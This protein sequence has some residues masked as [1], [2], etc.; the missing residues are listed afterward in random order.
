MVMDQAPLTLQT[1]FDP[2][3]F[4][5]SFQMG[6]KL[7]GLD[8]TKLN[9]FSK[10]YGD[11]DFKKGWFDLVVEVD[12]KEGGFDGYVKP[13]FRDLQIFSLSQD[14]PPNKNILDTFWE[15][16]VGTGQVLL[17]NRPRDQLATYIPMK[18]LLVSP[19]PD[20]LSAA[21]NILRNAFIRAYLPRLTGYAQQIEDIK[22]DAGQTID[23]KSVVDPTAPGNIP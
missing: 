15:A 7:I 13:L 1:K 3:S 8:V 6:L 20:I 10:S 17:T 21:G 19:K 5:P 16:L 23:P 11:F 18:G 4:N 9:D 22:F 14:L 12:A 2:F